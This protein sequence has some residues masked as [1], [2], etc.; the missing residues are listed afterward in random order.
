M[1]GDKGISRRTKC[2]KQLASQEILRKGKKM[3]IFI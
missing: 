2:I 3:G 1:W